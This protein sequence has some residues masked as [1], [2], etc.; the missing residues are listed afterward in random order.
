MSYLS[1]NIVRYHVS[2]NASKRL[3]VLLPSCYPRSLNNLED[4]GSSMIEDSAWHFL[5][6]KTKDHYGD[7]HKSSALT[8]ST[9][10]LRSNYYHH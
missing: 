6:K 10:G 7:Y 2:K 5:P 3:P 4:E 8:I 1:M 9:N